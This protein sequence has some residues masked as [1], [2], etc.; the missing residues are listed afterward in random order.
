MPISKAA[1]RA[2]TYIQS[3]VEAEQAKGPISDDAF[4]KIVNEETS[5][6]RQEVVEDVAFAFSEIDRLNDFK[7]ILGV[8][9]NT[10]T[11]ALM[12]PVYARHLGGNATL[13]YLAAHAEFDNL[14]L[15]PQQLDQISDAMISE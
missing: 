1:T 2:V 7:A 4:R 14:Q 5:G 10:A 3:R 6:L 9:I 13:G 15:T 12:E 8:D 11:A